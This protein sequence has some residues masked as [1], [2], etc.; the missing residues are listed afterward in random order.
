[1]SVGMA[2]ESGLHASSLLKESA[3]KNIA[4]AYRF[5]GGKRNGLETQ[6]KKK[7]RLGF[8]PTQS[9]APSG[10]MRLRSEAEVAA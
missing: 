10:G 2:V 3:F 5:Q 4:S 8:R 7:S 1:M 9:F 6:T